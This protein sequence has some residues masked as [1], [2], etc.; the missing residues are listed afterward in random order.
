MSFIKAITNHVD[1]NEKQS[2][3]LHNKVK[4][5]LLS[6]LDNG[7]SIDNKMV[8]NEFRNVLQNDFKINIAQQKSYEILSQLL[9]NK[10]YN[11]A[12]AKN[13]DFKELFIDNKIIQDTSNDLKMSVKFSLDR[14]LGNFNDNQFPTGI[15]ELNHDLLGGFDRKNLVTVFGKADGAN[16]LF[17]IS[18]AC[19]SLKIGRKV[20]HIELDEN[21]GEAITRYVSNLAQ[22][23][24]E[25]LRTNRLTSKEQNKVNDLKNEYANTLMVRTMRGFGVTIEDVMEYC[26]E[27]YKDF[28]FDVLVINY[29]QLLESKTTSNNFRL[30]MPHVFGS[31]S[32]LS[33][34]YNCLVITPVQ[35]SRAAYMKDIIRSTDV[36]DYFDIAR[37]SNVILS[38]N[39]T[40]QENQAGKMRVFLEKQ[41]KGITNKIYGIIV[42]F[43]NS[44]LLSGARYNV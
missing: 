17:S 11:V 37:V 9:G 10:N 5:F 1:I 8:I 16:S 30:T 26:S 20:L 40:R 15:S 38:L 23:S 36:A 43:K 12:L 7:Q 35:V 25:K 2:I 41:R 4:T 19:E 28:N 18:L 29:A 32:T 39:M 6:Q 34:K 31:L 24:Y 13:V 22:V 21:H 27:I 42:D 33:R 44:N 14:L 3:A